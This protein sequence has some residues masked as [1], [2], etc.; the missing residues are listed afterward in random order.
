VGVNNI[1]DIPL[2]LVEEGEVAVLVVVGTTRFTRTP[3]MYS[4]DFYR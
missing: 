3:A 1:A 2:D 4:F